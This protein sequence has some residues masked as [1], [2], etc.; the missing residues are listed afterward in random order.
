MILFLQLFTDLPD[1][2]GDVAH[3]FDLREVHRVDGRGRE[4]D[5]YHLDAIGLHEERGLLDDVVT[6]VDDQIGRLDRTM[7]EVA[8]R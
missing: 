4:V 1:A 7:D 5:V 8:R 2:V 6:H 3:H